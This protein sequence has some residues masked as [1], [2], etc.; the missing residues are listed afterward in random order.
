MRKWLKTALTAALATSF[1]LTAAAC[2]GDTV[3]VDAAEQ[4]A[5]PYYDQ[6]ADDVYNDDL[7][8]R[9][10][11]KAAC[12]DPTVIYIDDESDPDYGWFFM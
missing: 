4:Y 12:A 6:S 3:K 5:L 7:F 2:G 8:Y 1:A 9:N 11:M 10:D